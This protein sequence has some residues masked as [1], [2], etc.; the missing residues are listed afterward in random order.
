M[1][2]QNRVLPTGEIVAH[3]A[4]GLFT[5]N[6][7][8][9]HDAQGQLGASRWQHPHWVLCTLEHPRGIYHGPMP[10][11]GW[12][13]LFFLDEAVGLAAGHRPC[14]YCRRTAA[15]AFR[16]AFE[17][18]QGRAMDRISMD[19]TLHRAR[20]TR[21][22][23]QVRFEA[24]LQNLPDGTFVLWQDQP[25]LVQ[26]DRL[27]PYATSG[28]GPPLSRPRKAVTVLTPAPIV[29]ALGCGFAP[30]LHPSASLP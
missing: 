4:R 12:T 20:V 7:G 16:A 11:R 26:S 6:R 22:R 2:L 30:V 27:F 24:Q 18:G 21:Q 25:M 3:A 5:G 23:M 9:L 1:P 10:D 13:A 28:Y 17:A 15:Q 29:A 14:H 8:I 19:R